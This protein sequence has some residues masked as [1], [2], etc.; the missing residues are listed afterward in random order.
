MLAAIHRYRVAPPTPSL[1]YTSGSLNAQYASYGGVPGPSN[2]ATYGP[3]RG[4]PQAGEKAALLSRPLEHEPSGLADVDDDGT[5]GYV[6]PIESFRVDERT[7]VNCLDIQRNRHSLGLVCNITGVASVITTIVLVSINYDTDYYGYFCF[8]L[9]GY[10]GYLVEV[11]TS[12]TARF[13]FNTASMTAVVGHIETIK[14]RPLNLTLWCECYHY[15]TRVRIRPTPP[16]T[17]ISCSSVVWP[18]CN[19]LQSI[20]CTD[21]P[22]GRDIDRQQWTYDH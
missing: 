9:L 16:S 5:P 6:V 22:S 4:P 1:T 13:L 18:R 8:I 3:E 7:N 14:A 17:S 2:G 11:L 12:G 19:I 10:M 15:E 20:R 21:A